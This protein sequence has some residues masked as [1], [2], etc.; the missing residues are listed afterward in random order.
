MNTET[1]YPRFSEAEYSRRYSSVREAMRAADLAA[2]IFYSTTGSYHEV[3][4]LSNFI[5]AREACLVFP[6]EG[7]PTLLVQM[8]NHVPNARQL[9]N[10]VDVRWGGTDTAIA[11]AENLQE[12]KLD[13]SRIGLVGFLSF[14]QYNLIRKML[15]QAE[16]TDFTQQ[17]SHLRLIKSEEEMEFLRKGAECSDLAIEALEREARPGIPEHELAAIVERAY[18]GLGGKNH[19][20]YMGTTPMNN[21]SLC[22][23]TQF[24]SNRILQAGDV[25]LTEIS[26]HY[27][28]YAGQILRPFAIGTPPTPAY[29]QMYD[30]AVEAFNRIAAVIRPGATSDEVLDVSN[31]IHEAGFTICDDLV[32]GFGGGYLK[33]ILRT[34]RTSVTLPETFVFREGMVVVIQPNVI[35]ENGRMGIQVGEMVRVGQGG[36]ESLHQ[37]PMRFVQC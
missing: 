31:Y 20:H 10:I 36:V 14:K 34:R 24:Q 22:V 6:A 27:H 5:T 12:R 19:I 9:A 11:V 28:G 32:H 8:F 30:V 17:M 33:P 7:E 1:L 18:L 16:F 13:K 4:Y 26:A 35:T 37:Y 15:P 23:P 2:L 3:L 25:L 21:P 29:L